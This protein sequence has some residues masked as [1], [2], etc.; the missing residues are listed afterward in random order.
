MHTINDGA[1][2]DIEDCDKFL[3]QQGVQFLPWIG[4][5]YKQG[6]CS[7]RFLVL[8]ESHYDEWEGQKHC[9]DHSFTREC[10]DKVVRREDCSSFWKYIEQALVNEA[11]SVGWCPSGGMPLWE[12][13]AFYNFVQ[14][15]LPGG[16][17]GVIP[18]RGL[19]QK[20]HAPFRIVLE[21]LRP[22]RVIVCGKRLWRNM[23]D[24]DDND[25]HDNVQ[26]YRL[27]DGSQV[28]CLATAHPSSGSYSWKRVHRL[29][30]E[31]LDRPEAASELIVIK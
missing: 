16:P 15:P 17:R 25:C 11:R 3:V 5:K 8:G 21:Q 30:M 2:L 19:F 7:R 6:F 26:A 9:L 10:V 4:E 27:R 28:W 22:D 20:S 24:R 31:F 29:I 13:L 18:Q 23:E 1:I 12:K 14:E